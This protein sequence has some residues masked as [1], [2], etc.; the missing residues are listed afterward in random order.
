M[1]TIS[2]TRVGKKKDSSFRVVVV[3]SKRKVKA[4]NRPT[5]STDRSW[6]IEVVPGPNDDWIDEAG[7]KRFLSSDWKLSSKS[8]RTGFRLDGPQWTFAEKAQLFPGVVF[9]VGVDTAERIVQPRFYG[10]SEERM[11][12]ALEQI[13]QSG[14][15]FP[16]I[17]V[18]MR[19]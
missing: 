2:L 11:L 18:V 17:A 12:Q 6:T 1:L 3:E 16:R 7:Q 13:R 4:G 15:R 14:C 5:F 9:V 19:G 10:D 8:D